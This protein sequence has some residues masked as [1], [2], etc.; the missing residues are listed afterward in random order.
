MQAT[1]CFGDAPLLRTESLADFESFRG[2]L[3]RDIRPRGAVEEMYFADI[4]RGTWEIMRLGRA[5]TEIIKAAYPQAVMSLMRKL[6]PTF[7]PAVND[8]FDGA[9]FAAAQ[10]ETREETALDWSSSGD[11]QAKVRDFLKKFNLDDR[12]IEAEAVVSCMPMLERLEMMVISLQRQRSR[13]FSELCSYRE[14][15]ATG[16]GQVINQVTDGEGGNIRRLQLP[17]KRRA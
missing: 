7:D 10:Q 12:A 8:L 13:A 4:V 1:Q 5:K 14:H 2:G 17:A 9:S 16:L 15:Y 11:V 3:V 6:S